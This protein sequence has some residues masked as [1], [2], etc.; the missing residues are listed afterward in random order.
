MAKKETLYDKTDKKLQ[1]LSKTIGAIV[2]IVGAF[3]ALANWTS[4]RFSSAVAAQIQEFREEVAES[5]RKQDLAIMRMELL[6]LMEHDPDN[7]VE[8]EIL[9]KK[10][11]QAGG[12]SYMSSMYSR[13][14]REH[15]L[16]TS[17][18]VHE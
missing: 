10:Y 4:E 8:I 16:D 9:G 1:R 18:I 15:G 17:F 5:N 2:A 6:T 3:A 7:T 13:Y 14:A 12:N 11:F